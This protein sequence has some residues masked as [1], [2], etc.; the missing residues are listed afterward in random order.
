MNKQYR[1]DPTDT[2]ERRMATREEGGWVG[3]AQ[4]LRG[5]VGSQ[6]TV[7]GWEVQPGERGP[8]YCDGAGWGRVVRSGTRLLRGPMFELCLIIM[9]CT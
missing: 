5:Q 3:E 6:G 8:Q 9:L 1:N 2:E 4:Q 7:T